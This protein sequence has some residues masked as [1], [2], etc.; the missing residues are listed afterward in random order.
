MLSVKELDYIVNGVVDGVTRR[1]NDRDDVLDSAQVAKMLGITRK[2]VAQRVRA[3]KLPG[4]KKG[5]YLYFSKSE[6]IRYL[7]K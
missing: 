6:I 4:K 2:A 1:L 7:T 3:G 5:K